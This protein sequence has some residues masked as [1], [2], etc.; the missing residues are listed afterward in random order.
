MALKAI[1]P[2]VLGL[3]A[4]GSDANGELAG[5]LHKAGNAAKTMNV[6]SDNSA[7]RLP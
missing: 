7:H 3:H 2:N 5:A 1:S 6:K 4:I